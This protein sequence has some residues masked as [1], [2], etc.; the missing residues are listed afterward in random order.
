MQSASGSVAEKSA[1]FQPFELCFSGVRAQPAPV[2]VAAPE[3]K[4]VSHTGRILLVEDQ[5]NV[6]EFISDVLT[7]AGYRW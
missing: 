1:W 5:Q 6:R 2:E 3:P 7:G 4:P